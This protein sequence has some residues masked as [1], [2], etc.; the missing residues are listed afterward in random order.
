LASKIGRRKSGELNL[1]LSG[2]YLFLGKIFHKEKKYG[3]GKTDEKGKK[4]Y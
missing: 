4:F 3:T 1:R 2:L